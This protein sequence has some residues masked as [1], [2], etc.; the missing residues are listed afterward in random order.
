MPAPKVADA[1]H[2]AILANQL[3]ILTH[4]SS[5]PAI[6]ARMRNILDGTNPAPPLG[7]LESLKR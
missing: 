1:V 6:E 3:Y 5:Y 2:D 4:E 7:D